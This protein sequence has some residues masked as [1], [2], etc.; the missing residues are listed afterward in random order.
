MTNP[1][2]IYEVEQPTLGWARPEGAMKH[3]PIGR[4]TL[5]DLIG[6]GVIESHRISKHNKA[7]G[8]AI[9]LISLASLDAYIRNPEA[10]ELR[11]ANG[12]KGQ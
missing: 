4:T 1:E 6:R 7:R 2:N 12:V 5:Y 3:A 11:A 8:R 10:A 9:R